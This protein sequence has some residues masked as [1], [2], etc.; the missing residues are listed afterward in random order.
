MT[1]LIDKEKIL[2]ILNEPFESER[3]VSEEK[4]K[5]LMKPF[6]KYTIRFLKEDS[7][8]ECHKQYEEGRRKANYNLN[9]YPIGSKEYISFNQGVA[10]VLDL[11]NND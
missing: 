1:S 6:W 2:A 10:S 9:S 5:E 7:Y 11:S 4:R 3:G 8:N